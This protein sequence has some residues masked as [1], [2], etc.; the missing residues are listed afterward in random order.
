ME[1]YW[2]GTYGMWTGYSGPRSFDP[3]QKQSSGVMMEHGKR[4]S[5]I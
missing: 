5:K 2:V 3:S 1:K 4:F